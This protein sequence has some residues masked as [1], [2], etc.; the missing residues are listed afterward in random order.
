MGDFRPL[1]L[2]E[3][4]TISDRSFSLIARVN[5]RKCLKGALPQVEGHLPIPCGPGVL[6]EDPSS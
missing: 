6:N 3:K 5:S 2:T 4:L 1:P